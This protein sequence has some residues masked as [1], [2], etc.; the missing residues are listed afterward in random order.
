MSRYRSKDM[1]Q[2]FHT[3]IWHHI[4]LTRNKLLRVREIW[5]HISV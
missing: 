3:Q 4:S 2:M 1:S 5:C